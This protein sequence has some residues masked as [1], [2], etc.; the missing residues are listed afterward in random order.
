MAFCSLSHFRWK[1]NLMLSRRRRFSFYSSLLSLYRIDFV[2]KNTSKWKLQYLLN[3]IY[4][5]FLI[6]TLYRPALVAI[7][8]FNSIFQVLYFLYFL[9]L[10]NI[11]VVILINFISCVCHQ[12]GFTVLYKL[13]YMFSYLNLAHRVY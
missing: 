11:V 6:S 2:I 1:D 3:N 13:E 4:S 9:L 5:L 8:Y 7:I 12:L 10:Y